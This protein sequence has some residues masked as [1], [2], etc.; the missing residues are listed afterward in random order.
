MSVC[1]GEGSSRGVMVVLSWFQREQGS[2]VGTELECDAS[3]W[4]PAHDQIWF[5]RCSIPGELQ[6]LRVSTPSEDVMTNCT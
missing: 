5:G 4:T 1:V 6:C 2:K 3:C